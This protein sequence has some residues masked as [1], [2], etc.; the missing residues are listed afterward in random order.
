MSVNV[1]TLTTSCP[2][3]DQSPTSAIAIATL[4]FAA[5]AGVGTLLSDIAAIWTAWRT[6]WTEQLAA[7]LSR[8][9]PSSSS[10]TRRKQVERDD[11]MMARHRPCLGA[12]RHRPL[13][14]PATSSH[15]IVVLGLS[16]LSR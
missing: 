12:Q 10:L 7:H 1:H 16:S 13:G 4:V 9:M 6:P 8:S 15:L 2:P 3:C 14:P 5:I 11:P